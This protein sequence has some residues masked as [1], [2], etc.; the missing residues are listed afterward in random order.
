MT[1]DEAAK[2]GKDLWCETPVNAVFPRYVAK[3]ADPDIGFEGSKNLILLSLA[4]LKSFWS[5]VQQ[6]PLTIPSW[7]S[8]LKVSCRL[9][10][11]HVFTTHSRL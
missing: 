1:E 11:S 6:S 3:G 4:Q 7:P 2:F 5:L 8:T 9:V 10:K